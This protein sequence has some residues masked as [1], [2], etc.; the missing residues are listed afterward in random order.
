M[1]YIESLFM[2]LN[3]FEKFQ[4]SVIFDD[5]E[6]ESPFDPDRDED[7]INPYFSFFDL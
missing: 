7:D 1:N 3:S 5:E 4:T 6:E 2:Y